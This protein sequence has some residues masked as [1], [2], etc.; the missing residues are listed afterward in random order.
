MAGAVQCGAAGLHYGHTFARSASPLSPR[1]RQNIRYALCGK[2]Y[3]FP[4]PGRRG[5]SGG[6]G[7]G[8][9]TGGA[10]H[11]CTAAEGLFP[12]PFFIGR[13]CGARPFENMR[14]GREYRSPGKACGIFLTGRGRRAHSREAPC[15]FP[16]IAAEGHG[17]PKLPSG[18]AYSVGES[19]LPVRHGGRTCGEEY[20][21][22]ILV[23]TAV[24]RRGPYT[25]ASRRTD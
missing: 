15:F 1:S 12:S 11:G 22:M 16:M 18:K 10:F 5:G 25:G 13:S 17:D 3:P 24:F 2:G 20:F 23:M 4:R 9:I 21:Y 14:Q 8:R 19:C 6:C 7:N